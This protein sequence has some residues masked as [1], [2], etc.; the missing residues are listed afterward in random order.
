LE[1]H[2]GKNGFN[3]SFPT[4]L[5]CYMLD[6][7]IPA[8]YNKLEEI[9]GEL[10]VV[11]SELSMREAFNCGGFSPNDLEFCFESAFTPYQ[12]YS[13]DAIDGIDLVIKDPASR[14]LIPLEVKLT[15]LPTAATSRLPEKIGDANW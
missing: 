1:A 8:I 3:S 10:K 13:F 5:A 6:H 15:V 14:F 12:E 2:W 7:N 9:Y 11:S 4:A